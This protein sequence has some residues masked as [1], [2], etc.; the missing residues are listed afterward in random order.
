MALSSAGI[1]S[2]DPVIQNAVNFLKTMQN[3][4][5][6]FGYDGSDWGKVSD[7]ASDSWVISAIYAVGQNPSQWIK[8]TENPITHLES[9]QYATSGFFH[10]QQ[11]DHEN[12][13]TPTET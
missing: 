8:G 7:A 1:S 12:S 3:Q 5:G 4:D 9:L 2:T 13:F 11:G 10:H 6:G